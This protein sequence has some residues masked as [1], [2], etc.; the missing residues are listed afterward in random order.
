MGQRKRM[1]RDPEM[2]KA[3]LAGR[4]RHKPV[5]LFLDY[6]GTLSPIASSPQKALLPVR[7]KEL[8]R[9][10]AALGAR[11]RVAIVSGRPVETLRRLIGLRTV[12][13][14]GNH[15]FQMRGPCFSFTVA[16][17]SASR[18]GMARMHRALRRRL[19][20]V[21][22]VLIEHKGYSV[23]VHYRQV[24]P[25]FLPEVRAAAQEIMARYGAR[26]G[27]ARSDGKKVWEVRAVPGVT[28]GSAVARLLRRWP[29]A[30]PVFIG[31]DRTDEDAFAYLGSRGITV[32]VGRS[33]RTRARYRLGG[34]GQVRV[35]LER[36]YDVLSGGQVCRR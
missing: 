33:C 15:G 1:R 27:M 23:S 19:D 8:V 10:L 14:V 13:Y 12:V 3:W 35:F 28:K 2:T 24:P 20:A 16:L 22:G 30:L 7:T 11:C 9:R 4:I 5:A 29:N 34:P 25:R 18:A 32:R 17:S 36:L 31:D 21:A 6:D 26:Y